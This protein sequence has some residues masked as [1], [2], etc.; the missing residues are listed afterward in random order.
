M[1]SCNKVLS[2]TSLGSI[3]LFDLYPHCCHIPYWSPPPPDMMTHYTTKSLALGFLLGNLRSRL[4]PE[5][6]ES[7][8]ARHLEPLSILLRRDKA[9]LQGP[10]RTLL[11]RHN[12]GPLSQSIRNGSGKHASPE[13][14][15]LPTPASQTIALAQWQPLA[16]VSVLAHLPNH[17]SV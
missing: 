8:L 5:S 1:L 15:G 13:W 17:S 4:R 3:F 16:T 7:G 6:L 10:G 2:R 9:I 11:H 12:L 14:I